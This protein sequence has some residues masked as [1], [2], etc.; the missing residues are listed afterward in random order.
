MEEDQTS[1]QIPVEVKRLGG[2]VNITDEDIAKD[3]HLAHIM[4]R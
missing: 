1:R 4:E 2:I 3:K